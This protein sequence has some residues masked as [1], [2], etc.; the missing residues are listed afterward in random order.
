[1]VEISST[2]H[3]IT[4]L[5][6]FFSLPLLSVADNINTV[7]PFKLYVSKFFI[8]KYLLLLDKK[9]VVNFILIVC[10]YDIFNL[11]KVVIF[12]TLT[13]VT[14]TYH[15]NSFFPSTPFHKYKC[16]WSCHKFPFHRP[17][18]MLQK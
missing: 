5:R 15:M 13:I 8:C 10:L 14:L 18:D 3:F 6:I 12:L 9:N 11:V 7:T 2:T 4:M 17:L 1:M 16:H